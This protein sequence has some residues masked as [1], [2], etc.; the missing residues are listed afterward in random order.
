MLPPLDALCQAVQDGIPKPGGRLTGGLKHAARGE[1]RIFLWNGQISSA[2][3]VNIK[4]INYTKLHTY[5]R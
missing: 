4:T 3:I 2:T 1:D 5:D